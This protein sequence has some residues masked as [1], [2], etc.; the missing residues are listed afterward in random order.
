MLP[1]MHLSHV[2]PAAAVGVGLAVAAAVGAGLAVAAAVGATVIVL[3][4]VGVLKMI[5]VNV[6]AGVGLFGAIAVKVCRGVVLGRT[7]GADRGAPPQP[8]STRQSSTSPRL[9]PPP[10]LRFVV[11]LSLPAD[12]PDRVCAYDPSD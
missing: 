9:T 10:R 2:K 12:G 1:L 4:A 6:G 8:A 3:T 5:G 11:P 7:V